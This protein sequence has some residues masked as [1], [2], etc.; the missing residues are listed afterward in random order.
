LKLSNGE[1]FIGTFLEDN[2]EGDGKFYH[3]DGTVVTGKWSKGF[4]MTQTT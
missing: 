4:L 3:K 1:V 2:V